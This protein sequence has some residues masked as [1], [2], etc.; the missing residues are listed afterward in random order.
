MAVSARE[1]QHATHRDITVVFAQRR[2]YATWRSSPS[3]SEVRSRPSIS[4]FWRPSSGVG[5]ATF[6]CHAFASM[7]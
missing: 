4:S 6:S 5:A 7:T 2:A 3:I 1:A